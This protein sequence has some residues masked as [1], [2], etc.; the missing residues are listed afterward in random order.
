[1][2]YIRLM[3]VQHVAL[4][5]ESDRCKD[6]RESE[7]THGAKASSMEVFGRQAARRGSFPLALANLLETPSF[8][9]DFHAHRPNCRAVRYSPMTL[10][11]GGGFAPF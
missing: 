9:R 1:M 5:V 2:Y 10:V 4:R 6:V 3:H 11:M 7:P 8:L